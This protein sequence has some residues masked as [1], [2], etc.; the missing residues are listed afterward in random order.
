ML[1]ALR[2]R[3]SQARHVLVTWDGGCAPDALQH[4][5]SEAQASVAAGGRVAVENVER[6]VLS[7]HAASSFDAVL[8]GLAAGSIAVHCADVLAE[9]ARI[10][11]NGG[12][13][14]LQEPVDP[15]GAVVASDSILPS[16]FSWH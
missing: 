1:A 7:A 4:L 13:V 14:L 5:V 12:S 9:V 16:S 15:R 3:L 10:L 6:L 2:D 8:L 11:K